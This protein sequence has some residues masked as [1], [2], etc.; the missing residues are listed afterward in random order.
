MA[1]THA[2]Q[3]RSNISFCSEIHS[4]HDCPSEPTLQTVFKPVLVSRVSGTSNPHCALPG[5]H[6]K[7]PIPLFHLL[8]HR[9]PFYST[10]SFLPR[11]HL[12]RRPQDFKR[13]T[14]LESR[15]FSPS[16][17]Q[18]S[19]FFSNGFSLRNPPGKMF[20]SSRISSFCFITI[21][22]CSSFVLPFLP[23]LRPLGMKS[24]FL[25]PTNLAWSV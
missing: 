6:Y 10:L 22:I 13:S 15:I 4:S 17:I 12:L 2:P 23:L 16:G 9:H 25:Y 11:T 5:K 14:S 3:F 18:D 20:L 19:I 21:S 24:L 1:S 8:L 7:Y